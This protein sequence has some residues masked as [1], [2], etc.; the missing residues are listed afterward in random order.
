M[1]LD[2]QRKLLSP[3]SKEYQVKLVFCLPTMCD[4]ASITLWA[5]LPHI[6]CLGSYCWQYVASELHSLVIV[7]G[8]AD[9]L[10]KTFHRTLDCI[11][12]ATKFM[13]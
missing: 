6:C 5:D 4:K 13:P 11:M 3:R 12:Y 8:A 2:A 9:P 7:Q 1:K 10:A